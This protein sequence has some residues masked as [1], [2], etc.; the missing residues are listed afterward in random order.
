MSIIQKAGI[1]EYAVITLIDST[2]VVREAVRLHSP[3]SDLSIQGLGRL[4]TVTAFMSEG[5]K[6]REKLSITYD[7]DGGLG[8][9]VTAGTRH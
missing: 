4:L 7:T 3:M 5:F 8:R 6:G 9:L 1:G 2:E